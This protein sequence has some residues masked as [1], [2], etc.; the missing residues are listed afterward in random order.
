MIDS[1]LI[2]VAGLLAGL[3]TGLLWLYRRDRRR[4]RR[5]TRD[6]LSPAVARELM[7]EQE[8][9]ATRHE[10][11]EAVLERVRREI[12]CPPASQ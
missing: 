7:A 10:H 4:E 9:A 12:Q 5:R 3:F 6:T 2:V 11:F 8:A 1:A